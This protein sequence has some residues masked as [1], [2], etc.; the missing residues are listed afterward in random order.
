MTEAPDPRPLVHNSWRRRIF[1]SCSN[2]IIAFL[3][4]SL[5]NAFWSSFRMH[6]RIVCQNGS[7][8]PSL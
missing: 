5:A 8:W 4:L 7:H 2:L 3:V 1:F 6:Q